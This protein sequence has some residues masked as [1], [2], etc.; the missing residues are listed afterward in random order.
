LPEAVERLAP[1]LDPR[2]APAWAREIR[3]VFDEPAY[4]GALRARGVA[5]FGYAGRDAPA[6][7]TLALLKDLTKTGY[8]TRS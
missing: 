4:A 3:R 1:L 7:A 6:R 2:D 8:S 5:R